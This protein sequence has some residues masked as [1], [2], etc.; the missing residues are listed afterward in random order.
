MASPRV[1]QSAI[2]TL[3][4]LD[5]FTMEH[6]EWGLSDLARAAKTPKTTVARCL[7][8]LQQV[9]FLAQDEKTKNYR[10]GYRLM[11]LGNLV[12]D[13]LELRRVALPFMKSLSNQSGE[14]VRLTA[15]DGNEG[16]YLETIECKLPVRLWT[17]PN[18]RGP[19]Y[20]GA[21]RKILLAYLPEDEIDAI[22]GQGSIGYTNA[23]I[24]DPDKLKKHLGQ[25]RRQGW[26]SS[27]GEWFE[28][29]ACIAAPIRDRSGR[30]VG[31][32]SIVG[33][34]SRLTNRRM[35]ELIPMVVQ[36]ANAISG[37]FG[38]QNTD[39]EVGS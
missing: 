31:G 23:T 33:P 21:S 27:Q 17:P 10:L 3:K 9:G 1:S 8:S 14:T 25:I 2:K 6:W 15:L 30:V 13:K 20:A 19:L 38:Y 16:I 4:I 36:T 39:G 28:D 32:L 34:S 11:E 26:A 18:S 24:T 5:Y 7:D 22:I 35:K 12:R 29:S 37:G